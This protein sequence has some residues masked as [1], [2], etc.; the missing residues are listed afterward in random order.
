EQELRGSGR[1]ELTDR[2]VRR[3]GLTSVREVQRVLARGQNRQSL[4]VRSDHG[5]YRL[6]YDEI[7]IIRREI[8]EREAGIQQLLVRVRQGCWR[9][10][11]S[12]RCRGLLNAII[13]LAL[14][15]SPSKRECGKSCH[16]D[17]G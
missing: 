8:R 10:K 1:V 14:P 6:T 9:Y 12:W 2:A 4:T 5:L 16:H 15:H 3:P 13:V 17:Q 7:Q 11:Q